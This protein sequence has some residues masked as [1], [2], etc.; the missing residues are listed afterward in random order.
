MGE[1]LS[2]L[3]VRL[4]H[5]QADR[6]TRAAAAIPCRKKD[7]VAGLVDR[8]VDPDSDAGL[9]ALRAVAEL[10]RGAVAA[11][12]VPE[13]AP[14]GAPAPVAGVLTPATAA[15]LLQVGEAD[16]LELAEHGELPGRR[17]AGSWRFARTALLDWLAA[18][19]RQR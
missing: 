4:T 14:A 18:P 12:L 19:A 7:L 13:A 1:D 15:A 6:L 5:E 9:D 16:V 8:Y 17:I 10:G 2:P 3:F 11:A